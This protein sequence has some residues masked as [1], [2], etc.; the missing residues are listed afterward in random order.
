MVTGQS[1]GSGRERGGFALVAVLLT[2]GAL[3]LLVSA[4][5]YV[6]A[7]EFSITRSS[8][9]LLRTRLAAESAVRATM[10][11][12]RTD[13]FLDLPVGSIRAAPPAEYRATAGV[14]TTTTI[15][16]LDGSLF[17]LR[18]LATTPNGVRSSAAVIVRT[19]DPLELWRALPAALTTA[20]PIEY[21]EDDAIAGFDPGPDEIG[22]GATCQAAVEA[23]K[24]A[25]G[26]IQRP[27]VR[28]PPPGTADSLIFGPLDLTALRVLADRTLTGTSGVGP[29]EGAV[30]CSGGA[31]CVGHFPL[32]YAPDGFRIDDGAWWGIM[33]VDGGLELTG[34]AVFHGIVLIQGRLSMTGQARIYGAALVVGPEAAVDITGEARLEYD[35]CAVDAAIRG[36]R[37][38][39]NAYHPGDRSWIPAF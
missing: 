37:L 34:D 38:T 20:A 14:E 25:F 36:G 27:P 32:V 29:G 21:A 10:T 30:G 7:E 1:A 28:T 5:L 24:A 17:L 13:E 4:L 23:L 2:L 3:G 35:P 16:R 11:N 18:A 8:E 22:G 19:I 6:S 33:V 15:E 31:P 12:W 26:S 9:E 39:S